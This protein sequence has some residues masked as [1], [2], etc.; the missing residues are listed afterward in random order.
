MHVRSSGPP[1]ERL[2][3][4]LAREKRSRSGRA[5][6]LEPMTIVDPVSIAAFDDA[7]DGH[8]LPLYRF[9]AT[10]LDRLLPDGGTLLDLGCGSGRFLA[11]LA[12]ARPDAHVIGIDLSERMI[13]AGRTMLR[14]RALEGRVELLLSDMRKAPE[15]LDQDARLDVISSI[16]SLHHL[17][18]ADDIAQCLQWV[19][20]LSVEFHCALWIFDLVRM[21]HEDT[22]AAVMDF[23][24]D[25]SSRLREDAIISERA[26]WTED[27]LLTLLTESGLGHARGGRD[28]STGHLQAWWTLPEGYDGTTQSARWSAPPLPSR[29][30]I[31]VR[32][33]EH[34]FPELPPPWGPRRLDADSA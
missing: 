15:M 5:R 19:A 32:R 24:G 26:A 29:V 30:E 11:H 28:R 25:A 22:M 3:A 31:A 27:E 10:M 20:S 33:L 14:G 17:P 6:V 23:S 8:L 13:R 1:H 18:T 16:F 4:Q 21:R 7:A 9:N 2:A 12:E 34:D